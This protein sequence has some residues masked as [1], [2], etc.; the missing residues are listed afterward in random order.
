MEVI[1]DIEAVS[2]INTLANDIC[3]IIRQEAKNNLP[4]DRLLTI[5]EIKKLVE[6]AAYKAASSIFHELY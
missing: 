1:N 3:N 4:D 2:M 5:H 6:E